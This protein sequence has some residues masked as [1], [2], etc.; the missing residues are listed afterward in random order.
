MDY[1]SYYNMIHKANND[2]ICKIASQIKETLLY[3]RDIKLDPDEY[4]IQTIHKLI[5]MI[6]ELNLKVLHL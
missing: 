1:S 4:N 2:A 5:R 3:S 6:K